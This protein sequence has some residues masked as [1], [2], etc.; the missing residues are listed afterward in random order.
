MRTNQNWCWVVGLMVLTGAA[1]AQPYTPRP[2]PDHVQIIVPQTRTIVID[3]RPGPQPVQVTAVDATVNVRNQAATTTLV[4]SLRNP[5]NRRQEA[6]LMVPVPDSAVVRGL[7]FQG[8]GSEPS[9][10]LLPREEARRIYNEIVSRA[11]DPALLEFAGLNVIRSSVFPVEPN[12]TQKIKLIYEMLLKADGDRFDYLLPRS[13]ALDYRVPWRVTMNIRSK[14]KISTVYSPTHPLN[15]K[16]I[17]DTHVQ[18]TLPDHAASTPGP[19]RV[20]CLVTDNGVTASLFAYPDPKSGGGYFLLLAGVPPLSKQVIQ[21]NA[22]KR[23]VTLVI[24]RSGSMNGPK[25]KQVREAAM[26]VIAGLEMG[27]AFNVIIYNSAVESFSTQPVIKTEETETAVRRYLAGMTARGGTNIH[28]ALVEALRQKPTREMLPLVLFLTDGLPTIGQTSEKAIRAMV[29]TGNPFKRRVFTFGVGVDVNTPLL[30]A[31][32]DTTRATS[33]FVLPTEDVEVKVAAVFK[34]LTGPVLADPVMTVFDASGGAAL[35]RT[36][37]LMPSRLPDL[38]DGDQLVL[39]GR[40]LG[41]KPIQFKLEG[42][43]LT[44]P[45]TFAFDF[46]LDNATT[47]NAFVPRLWASRKIA[48]LIDAIRTMGADT[49]RPGAP[50]PTNDPRFK[51]LVDE[52]VKLSTEFGILTEYTA[53]LAREGTDLSNERLSEIR[54]EASYNFSRRAMSTRSGMASTNQD[55]NIKLGK[56]QSR[57]NSTN[58][59]YDQNMRQVEISSVQQINDRTFYR[60]GNQWI[61]S[62][63]ISSSAKPIKTVRVGTEEY[64]QIAAKLAEKNQQGCMSFKENVVIEI[65]NQAMCLQV[66]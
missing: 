48:M 27:E 49:G 5:S 34:R 31:V 50:V 42:N 11:K 45:R 60:R 46:E 54:R 12:G 41:D 59:Y 44:K 25:L 40:Y 21:A 37:D 56:A 7:D 38:F 15:V 35:G 1:Q 9:A 4:I 16:R 63:L 19:L 8:G 36:I 62:R 28:D 3:P 32:A 30:E 33:E 65:D 52:I 23:E 66:Q 53:F 51:E 26:Q 22:A 20:S 17:N 13:E 24:D 6:E 58:S 14:K 57:L 39:V 43:Y 2:L 55:N 47:K 61:D 10:Q 64:A 29:K 18:V